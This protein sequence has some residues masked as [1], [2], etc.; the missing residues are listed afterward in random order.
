[1]ELIAPHEPRPLHQEFR[2]QY[3]DSF[4]W[5]VRERAAGRCRVRITKESGPADQTDDGSDDTLEVTTEL[6]VRD[7]PPAQR[8]EQIFEAY[9]QLESGEAFVLVND[10]DPEPLY[11]QF[12]AETGP[13]FRWNYR[14]KDPGEFRV[15]IGKTAVTESESTSTGSTETPF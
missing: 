13:E 6:D 14:L 9:E 15:R 10:H 1:M 2:Q 12:E 4:S 3:G 11:H 5:D 8:H 7:L